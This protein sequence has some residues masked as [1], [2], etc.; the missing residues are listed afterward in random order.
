MPQMTDGLQ[1]LSIPVN[2]IAIGTLASE[3]ALAVNNDI[4]GANLQ[5][6]FLCKKV[7]IHFTMVAPDAEDTLLVFLANGDLSVAEIATALT[8]FAYPQNPND[9]S[10]RLQQPLVKGIWWET[11]QM[12]SANGLGSGKTV[13]NEVV[14]LGGGKGI[15]AIRNSGVSLFVYNPLGSAF[16]AGSFANGHLLFYGAWLNDS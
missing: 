16:V 5:R 15:P 2:E 10:N 1:M 12:I 7:R 3:T 14:K 11:M 9:P 6:S 8:T 13:I 4:G